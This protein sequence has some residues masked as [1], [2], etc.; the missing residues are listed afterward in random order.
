MVNQLR[1]ELIDVIDTIKGSSDYLACIK[2]KDEMSKNS[3]LMELI[4]RVKKLQKEYVKTKNMD[5]KEELDE[6]QQKLEQNPLYVTYINHLEK[7]NSMISYVEEDLNQ[8]FLE[9]TN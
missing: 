4:S 7:V 3:N 1:K 9:L 2:L 6:C 5:L 8:F